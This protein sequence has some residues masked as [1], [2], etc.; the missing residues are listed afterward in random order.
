M[1]PMV[2]QKRDNGE[3]KQGEGYDLSLLHSP[4]QDDAVQHT[5]CSSGVEQH[6]EAYL[7]NTRRAACIH[8]KTLGT[9]DSVA[10]TKTYSTSKASASYAAFKIAA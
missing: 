2:L 8:G 4:A 10:S 5:I 6:I 9:S 1:V 7:C 3:T